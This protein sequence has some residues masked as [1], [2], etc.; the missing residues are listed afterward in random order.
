LFGLNRFYLG[1]YVYSNTYR[2]AITTD[3]KRGHDFE[4]E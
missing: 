3:G 4:G 2:H 1:I